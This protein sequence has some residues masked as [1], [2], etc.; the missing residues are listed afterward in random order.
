MT[1]IIKKFHDS[2]VERFKKTFQPHKDMDIDGFGFTMMAFMAGANPK[3]PLD[4]A[5]RYLM[6]Y[7][8]ELADIEYELSEEYIEAI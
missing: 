2:E 6:D 4:K 3:M 5:W 7:R 8:D 1:D